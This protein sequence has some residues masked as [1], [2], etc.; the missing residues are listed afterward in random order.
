MTVKWFMQRDIKEYG[1]YDLSQ[2][3]QFAREKTVD[4][5]YGNTEGRNTEETQRDG[6]SVLLH[7]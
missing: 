5:R 4:K 6:S 1:P 2:L 3:E 7:F